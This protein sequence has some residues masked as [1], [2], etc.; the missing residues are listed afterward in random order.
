MSRIAKASLLLF[1][2]S[3]CAAA[4]LVSHRLEARRPAPAPQ[5]LFAVVNNQLAAFRAADFPSAYRHAATGMQQKFTL[6][7]FEAMVRRNY[8]P[9][10][11]AQRVEFGPVKTQGSNAVVQV[12]FFGARGVVRSFL[13]S[14]V[15]EGDRWKIEGVQE[16][17]PYRSSAALAGSHA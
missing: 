14:L 7:Q 10:T 17:G 1:F 8:A 11:R 9:M 6:P 16:L 5:D 12:F 13:Y 2:F 4:F 3:L 15:A